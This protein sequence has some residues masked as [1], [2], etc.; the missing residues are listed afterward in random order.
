[1]RKLFRSLLSASRRSRC[2]AVSFVL[3]ILRVIHD[4]EEIEIAR[5]SDLLDGFNL[6]PG[7]VSRRSYGEVEDDYLDCEDA[8]GFLDSAIEN[9]EYAYEVRS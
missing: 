1:M 8:L 3:W 2:R 5:Y 9:L 7:S 4:I 6:N